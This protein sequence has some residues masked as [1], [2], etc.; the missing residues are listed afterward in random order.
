MPDI[1]EIE[2]K[3]SDTGTDR[4]NANL[5]KLEQ[6]ERRAVAA[7]GPLER[8][9]R[10]I[11]AAATGLST[12]SDRLNAR[13]AQMAAATAQSNARLV[14][15]VR[16]AGALGAGLGNLSG[17]L[18]TTTAATTR[19]V[20]A[21][22]TLRGGLGGIR[23]A[24]RDAGG[25]FSKLGASIVVANQAFALVGQA[26]RIVAAAVR[27]AVQPAIDFETAWTGVRKTVTG[28]EQDLRGLQV[29]LAGLNAQLPLSTAEVLGVAEAAGQLGIKTAAI[30]GFTETMVM[31]GATTNLSAQ[32]AATSLARLA[33]ITQLPQD[34]F[35]R[36]GSTV[37]ALG[38]N[39]ATTEQEIVSMA[40]RIAGA[41]NQVG[42]SEA[43]ILSFAATLSSLGIEAEAGGTAISRIFI[44]IAKAV[45]TGNASLQT[46]ASV[47]GRTSA[48]FA[49]AFRTNAAQATQAFI[50]GLAGIEEQGG[51]TIAILEELGLDDIR[52]GDALRRAA[53]GGDLL[54]RSL[55]LGTKAWEDNTALAKEAEQRF[56]TVASQ[57]VLLGKDVEDLATKFGTGLLPAV[58]DSITTTREFINLLDDGATEAGSSFGAFLSSTNREFET[59]L[60]LL[61]GIRD[62]TP[63]L[64][65]LFSDS[66]G[67]QAW[68]ANARAAGTI[69]V[70]PYNSRDAAGALGGGP[71][72][73][74]ALAAAERARQ[75]ALRAAIDPYGYGQSV[76]PFPGMGEGEGT[77]QPRARPG[78]RGWLFNYGMPSSAPETGEVGPPVPPGWKAPR[79]PR[80]GGGGLSPAE[81]SALA[82]ADAGVIG[83]DT[84][85]AAA[86]QQLA[87][88]Q[89]QLE[90]SERLATTD[91]ERLAM[92]TA[93]EQQQIAAAAELD[94]ARQR[95]LDAEIAVVATK[96]EQQ[97]LTAGE[98]A[99]LDAQI[100]QLEDRRALIAGA[101]SEE[102]KVRREHEA[103]RQALTNGYVEQA[104]AIRD[105]VL[106]ME[107]ITRELEKWRT[108][109]REIPEVGA[110]MTPEVLEGFEQQ[111]KQSV[112]DTRDGFDELIDAARQFGQDFSRT[113]AEA[114]SP[115]GAR[116]SFRDFLSSLITDVNEFVIQKTLTDPLLGVVEESIIKPIQGKAGDRSLPGFLGDLGGDAFDALFGGGSNRPPTQVI[117]GI[118]EVDTAALD[119]LAASAD[120]A[121]ESLV[122][123]AG[124]TASG[125][126]GIIGEISGGFTDLFGSLGEG[127]GNL[128]SSLFGED[129]LDVGGLVT[130]IIG[131][132]AGAAGGGTAHRG[133]LV[134]H[135]GG[136][137]LRHGEVPIIAEE[138]ELILSRSL[139][140]DLLDTAR[141]PPMR[142]YHS[143]GLV[144]RA[145]ADLAPLAEIRPLAR[146]GGAGGPWDGDRPV[147]G[148]PPVY[149][150]TVN[151]HAQSNDPRTAA[152]LLV[153]QSSTIVGIIRRDIARGGGLSR[154]V[155]QRD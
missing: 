12:T 27:A 44:E 41:G 101:A 131:G 134:Y 121:G 53:G 119:A 141:R 153:E 50:A 96:R 61:Q 113:M 36:L 67:A 93:S 152:Q 17:A 48:E 106:P 95:Q 70:G 40:L 5:V 62:I 3:V 37:V 16:A 24:V 150:I 137:V 49:A 71:G 45:E 6:S 155:G 91:A 135:R 43:Q 25:G 38:N 34:Q 133:A 58:K 115:D 130:D 14:E 56:A 59:L 143:G 105:S 68:R 90:V 81:R 32:D 151:Q 7:A 111:Q 1:A 85:V 118:G 51:S 82:F 78:D 149:N 20:A 129:G 145:G 147:T 54:A 9:F 88:L 97:D 107:A 123:A 15:G 11:S 22:A 110:I 100:D 103:T 13:W 117:P 18:A 122:R 136:P 139:T 128:L 146:R 4:A 33:N 55:E 120:S 92:I 102:A 89:E 60:G 154:D 77:W 30:A 42:L 98:R 39:L 28:S 140:R 21:N 10:E 144:D 132:L 87:L 73:A 19:A 124:D 31:L 2:I 29:R 79:P 86:E 138:G 52:V 80:R 75:L 26:G 116:I 99:E 112:E 125:F 46:F 148:Q 8:T 69:N 72:R 83:A 63:D 142:R 109:A 126:G 65:W 66:P 114:L 108:L 47:S 64:S 23:D 94:A 84:Q 104:Q 127:I 74:D 35:D 76:L 57:L